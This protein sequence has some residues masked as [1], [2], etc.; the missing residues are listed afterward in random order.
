MMFC[1]HIWLSVCVGTAWLLGPGA[2]HAQEAFIK[3]AEREALYRSALIE[4]NDGYTRSAI[5]R[6][7]RLTA[8]DPSHFGGWL[9]LAI[10][11]CQVGDKE[12][13]SAIL[14]QLEE[15][16]QVP[17]AIAA[18]IAHYRDA[19]CRPVTLPW[20]PFV[21]LGMG[22]ANNVNRGPR[23]NRFDL[24]PF[25]LQLTLAETSRP[26]SA[27]MQIVEAG[28]ERTATDHQPGASLFFQGTEYAGSPLDDARFIQG[29]VTAIRA[30]DDWRIATRGMLSHLVLGGRSQA[31]VAN[32][33][34]SALR[35]LP[36]RP[37]LQA[38]VSGSL[39]TVDYPLQSSYRATIGEL[40]GRMQ[41]QAQ[42]SLRFLA[43]AG[44][45]H[46]HALGARPGGSRQGP[47]VQA[48]V[49]WRPVPGNRLG[50]HFRQNRPQDEAAYSPVFFGETKRAPRT[51]FWFAD[52]SKA[53][54]GEMRLRL[55]AQYSHQT[56]S[57]PLF[58]Y[59]SSSVMVLLEWSPSRGL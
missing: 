11:W 31:T 44:W 45:S 16:P 9:D 41:W 1:K 3:D 47:V 7:S 21:A 4:L 25:G 49:H 35:P 8:E 17:E 28:V 14:Q 43:D 53:L 42:P 27:M 37:E 39:T 52:W 15:L 33:S 54:N 29:N 57:I 59:R 48:S 50:L 40:R 38:G 56:D 12:R 6:L 2:L 46:D 30:V 10:A 24:E 34:F 18:L 26:R 5:E 22:H 58:A 36:E 20:R 19:G 55:E 32:L 23:E 13:A 51:S